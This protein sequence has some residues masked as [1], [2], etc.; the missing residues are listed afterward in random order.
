G[1]EHSCKVVSQAFADPCRLARVLDC[2]ATVIAAHCGTCALFDPVDYYPNF[3][4]MMQRYDNLYGDTSIMTSLIRPGSL[5]RLSRESESIK[6][7]IL[8]GSDYPFPPSRLPFLFRTGVLPQQRRN[9]LD[10]D[11]RIKRSFGFGSGY[12]SLVLELMG[13][14]P[15]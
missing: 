11:L 4:R 9:P 14:E 1:Y 3:I 15:G 7:R 12:S 13:V 5:K 8:H 2:G 6:A 10:M